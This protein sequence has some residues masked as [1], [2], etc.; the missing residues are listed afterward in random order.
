MGA[1]GVIANLL[2]IYLWYLVLINFGS[3]FNTFDKNSKS[4]EIKRKGLFK[5]IEVNLNFDDIKSVKLDISEGFN[6]RRRITLVLKG[7]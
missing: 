6:P 5:D 7:R 2:N 3:G 1:Y 4:V